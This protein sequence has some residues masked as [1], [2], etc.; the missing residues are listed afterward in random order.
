MN[1]NT[2]ANMDN[3]VYFLIILPVF[4]ILFWLSCIR[5]QN[6]DTVSSQPTE[7]VRRPKDSFRQR[8]VTSAAESALDR[9]R[10]RQN[11]QYIS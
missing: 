8:S 7:R 9:I 10:R 3:I 6:K 11:V 5:P 2:L 4:A 1:T